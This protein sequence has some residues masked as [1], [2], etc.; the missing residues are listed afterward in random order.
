MNLKVV[1][2]I[3]LFFQILQLIIEV[4]YPKCG[5]ES[6]IVSEVVSVVIAIVVEAAFVLATTIVLR[7]LK[8]KMKCYL[9]KNL[10]YAAFLLC[11]AAMI[12]LIVFWINAQNIFLSMS[13][14][15]GMVGLI[16]VLS[17][18]CSEKVCL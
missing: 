10:M 13:I 2:A 15:F 9:Y 11:L 12:L 17:N 8:Q 16:I 6:S 5:V 3:G 18:E 4:G 1:Y 14:G 7:K